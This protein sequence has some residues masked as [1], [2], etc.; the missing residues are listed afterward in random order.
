MSAN[1]GFDFS[2]GSAGEL[3]RT[4]DV[5]KTSTFILFEDAVALN[6]NDETENEKKHGEEGKRSMI[7]DK[8][9][10]GKSACLERHVS[11]AALP[12][13]VAASSRHVVYA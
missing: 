8:C 4:L 3:G 1:Q 13:T 7:W 11:T 5:F 12:W 2:T 9:A 10:S 6:R